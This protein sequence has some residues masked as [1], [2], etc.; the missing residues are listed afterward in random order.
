MSSYYEDRP[1]TDVSSHRSVAEEFLSLGRI[2]ALAEV[3][4]SYALEFQD[5]M[6]QLYAQKNCS[7][8]LE[9]CICRLGDRANQL[10]AVVL[11]LLH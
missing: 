4:M 1:V 9:N 7:F 10:L 2:H 6:L 3:D 5:D 11:R 8:L